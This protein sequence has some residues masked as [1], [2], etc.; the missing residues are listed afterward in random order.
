VRRYGIPW[1]NE[2]GRTPESIVRLDPKCLALRVRL[3]S[4]ERVT[5]PLRPVTFVMRF[6]ADFTKPS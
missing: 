2:P 4:G 3:E 1:W 5:M 6:P